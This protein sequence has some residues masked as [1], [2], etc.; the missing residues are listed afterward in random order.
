AKI[1]FRYKHKNGE[2]KYLESKGKSYETADGHLRS[3]IS[4]TDITKKREEEEENIRIEKLD[5]LAVL[6]GGIAHDFNNLLSAISGNLYLAH[7]F[8]EDSVRSNERFDE[9]EKAVER[10][11][12]LTQQLLT[13]AK[14]D[15]PI[16]T[17][18]SLKNIL[19]DSTNFALRGSNV[20]CIFSIPEDLSAVEI[21]AG[22]ISQVINNLAINSKQSMPQGGTIFVSAENK[23]KDEV[24]IPDIKEDNYVKISVTDQGCGITEEDIPKIFDPYFTTKEEGSG[25]GLA[26]TYSVIKKHSGFIKVNSEIDKGTTF[27]IYL[28][29][30]NKVITNNSK[31]DITEF[32]GEGRVL[33][34]D[35]DYAI[36]DMLVN[37]IENL[38]FEVDSASSGEE[39]LDIYQN[40]KDT[41]N[42]YKFVLLDITIPGGMGGKDTILKLRENEPDIKAIAIS[43]YSKDPIS[44]EYE[45][46]GFNGFIAKPFKIKD[47]E[48]LIQNVLNN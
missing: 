33:L 3:V 13:F 4:S 2:W 5:S 8:K 7:Q 37:I 39:A 17:A 16:R 46:F 32:K 27:T 19:E 44:T 25:L 9:A 11:A 48:S 40:T 43:G 18:S 23:A 26:T 22:Q 14:G 42:Q 10:A 15:A 12:D 38:G 47:F 34:M 24:E 28:P 41:G 45:D 6:T 1:I 31:S 29:A 36:R 20:K 30:L 21:N 35:D